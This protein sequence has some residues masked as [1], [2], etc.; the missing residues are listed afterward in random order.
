[1]VEHDV[2]KGVGMYD[3]E[4]DLSDRFL[5]LGGGSGGMVCGHDRGMPCQTVLKLH[6]L[7][8]PR[9]ALIHI[10]AHKEAAF[11]DGCQQRL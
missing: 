9:L 11:L 2:L 8:A 1:L 4:E 6:H 5:S 10:S 3:V 7:I